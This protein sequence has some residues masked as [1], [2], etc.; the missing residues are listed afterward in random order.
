VVYSLSLL[1]G[2]IFGGAVNQSSTWRWVFLLKSA[3][4]SPPQSFRLTIH[5]SVPAG[6]V[7]AVIVVV[8]IPNR[9]PRHHQADPKPRSAGHRF[10]IQNFRKV[11]IFGTFMLLTATTLLVAALQEAGRSF[12]WKSAFV[13][14]MLVISGLTWP[15]FLV[16]ERRVT[17][18]EQ[19]QEPIFPWRFVQSRVWAGMLLYV[20]FFA[21]FHIPSFMSFR[22]ALFLGGPWFVTM[23]QIPQRFQ[24]V[25]NISPLQAGIR[26]IPFT[27]AAP[28]GS[29]VGPL[30]AK[31]AKV[32]P[33][34]LVIFASI[35]QVV[36][37]ALLSSLP[38]SDSISKAQYGYEFLAGFGCGINI[39]LLILM[40]PFSVKARDKGAY[41]ASFLLHS[42][43][44]YEY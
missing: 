39:T 44:E 20:L 19:E 37:F 41:M 17:L 1:L 2:P 25:D 32:P 40:T 36:G 34:Y 12:P 14:T 42:S 3:H 21:F 9:F 27:L 13:I 6:I 16:W 22:N 35:T 29:V 18:V 43:N 24:F 7:A 23:F 26:F 15:A 5:A 31:V 4:I 38:A 11:D 33:I 8:S 28:V 10:S 30:I